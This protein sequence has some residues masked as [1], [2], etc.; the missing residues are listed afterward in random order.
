VLAR[1]LVDATPE[2]EP[3]DIVRALTQPLPACSAALIICG[4][5]FV[6]DGRLQEVELPENTDDVDGQNW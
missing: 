2:G 5:S 6:G 1:D 4:L 3:V